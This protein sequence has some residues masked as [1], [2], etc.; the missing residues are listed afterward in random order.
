M[1]T[2]TAFSTKCEILGTLW[3]FYKDTD[4]QTW[5]EFFAWAD[6]GLPLSY[7]VWQG[8]A[9]AKTEGKK[10]VEETWKVFCEMIEIDPEG[11][12]ESLSDA[13]DASSKPEVED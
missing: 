10:V 8:L 2:K 1:P 6:L 9:T 11:N 13:F 5:K 3:T 12:Y 4:N 7:Q